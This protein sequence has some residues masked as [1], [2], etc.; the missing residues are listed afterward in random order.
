MRLPD[1]GIVIRELLI[2]Q[3]A[4]ECDVC[5]RLLPEASG[6]SPVHVL[7]DA[8]SN[9]LIRTFARKAGIPTISTAFGLTGTDRAWIGLTEQESE[10]LI[11]INPPEDTMSTMLTD[12]VKEFGIR[13]AV[14]LRDKSFGQFFF[15]RFQSI[16]S[17]VSN[18]LFVFLI[19]ERQVASCQV[20]Y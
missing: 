17:H 18:G 13:N 7:I 8:T 20:E 14:L 16:I 11:Q 12:L 1:T 5:Q 3:N 2:D 4:S 10:W 15:S 6:G 9:P 19:Q